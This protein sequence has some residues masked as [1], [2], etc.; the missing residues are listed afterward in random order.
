MRLN[1][2][3]MLT[4]KDFSTFSLRE[5]FIVLNFNYMNKYGLK[6]AS[7]IKLPCMNKTCCFLCLMDNKD[8]DFLSYSF[9][10]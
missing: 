9:E 7:F 4:L 2:T 6:F 10:K 3:D 8:E 1:C 5:F